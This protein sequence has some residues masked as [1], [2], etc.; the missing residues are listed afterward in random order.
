MIIC[1]CVHM[2]YRA[3][4]LSGEEVSTSSD[5][6]TAACVVKEMH[7]VLFYNQCTVDGDLQQ[8]T[9]FVSKYGF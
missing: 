5:W 2:H 8:W 3:L 6:V 7:A 4:L 9:R 1:T